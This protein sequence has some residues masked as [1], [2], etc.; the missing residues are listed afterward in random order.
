[1]RAESSTLTRVTAS[2]CRVYAIGD[3]VVKGMSPAEL[4]QAIQFY[5]RDPSATNERFGAYLQ[6]IGGSSAVN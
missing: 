5:Q 2:W 3:L 1:M 6:S 4:E